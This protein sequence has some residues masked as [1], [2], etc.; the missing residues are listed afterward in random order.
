[1]ELYTNGLVYRAVLVD[2]LV[3]KEPADHLR[4]LFAFVYQKPIW[5]TVDTLPKPDWLVEE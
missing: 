5:V 4:R 2:Q 3:T 1:V